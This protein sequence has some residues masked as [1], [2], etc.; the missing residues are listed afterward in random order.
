MRVLQLIG[1]HFVVFFQTSIV[2][3]VAVDFD[4]KCLDALKS[5][6]LFSEM[7]VWSAHTLRSNIFQFQTGLVV[8]ILRATASACSDLPMHFLDWFTQAWNSITFLKYLGEEILFLIIL[9]PSTSQ[10]H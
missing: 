2:P 1:L 8:Q 6:T 4:L 7:P 3:V 5:I 10:F 9:L